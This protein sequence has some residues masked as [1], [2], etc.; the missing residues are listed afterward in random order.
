MPSVSKAQQSAAGIA[1]AV[2]KGELPKSKLRGASKRMFKSMKG[3]GELHKFAATK[4][5]GL[6]QKK[7]EEGVV[8]TA[9]QM[10]EREH[11]T[12][13]CDDAPKLGLGKAGLAYARMDSSDVMDQ[14]GGTAKKV[15]KRYDMIK[16]VT[17][18]KKL[19]GGKPG[20][21]IFPSMDKVGKVPHAMK[22]LG[23]SVTPQQV[24]D[25][26]LAD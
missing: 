13:G 19:T 2:E 9:R 1:H 5:K 21:K 25:K 18:Q 8:M 20:S 3:A 17:N 7:T 23:D 4:T 15:T 14:P 24:V 12:E 16:D 22:G 11:L 26:L 6:P 10:F